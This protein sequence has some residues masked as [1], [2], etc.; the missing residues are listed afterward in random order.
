MVKRPCPVYQTHQLTHLM[1]FITSCTRAGPTR[2]NPADAG[3]QYKLQ[4]SLQDPQTVQRAW[5]AK[6]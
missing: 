6:D 1:G 5:N 4:D 2:R 3:E